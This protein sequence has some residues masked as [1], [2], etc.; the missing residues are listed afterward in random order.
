MSAQAHLTPPPNQ[1]EAAIGGTP[2]S[3]SPR[4]DLRGHLTVLDGVGGLAVLMVL[5]FNFVGQMLPTYW[6]ESAIVGVTK[7]GERSFR[8]E[9]RRRVIWPAWG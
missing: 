1:G 8:P 4:P 3:A 7:Y 9:A 2:P 6:V 5:L